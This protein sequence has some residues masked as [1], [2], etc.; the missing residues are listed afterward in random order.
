MTAES[1]WEATLE[2]REQEGF[3]LVKT[4]EEEGPWEAESSPHGSGRIFQ[5][6]FRQFRYQEASGPR[7]ALGRLRELCHLWL[8][9]DRRTKEQ[10]LDLLVLEQFLLVLPE[11][12]QA[13]VRLHRPESG[14]EAVAVV[15]EMQG[16]QNEP[17][18]WFSEEKFVVPACGSRSE[19]LEEDT[20]APGASQESL[21]TSPQPGSSPAQTEAG[22]LQPEMSLHLPKHDNP[23]ETEGRESLSAKEGTFE[24]VG[25]QR[26]FR[27][28][29]QPNILTA[30]AG[31]NTGEPEG[32]LE[33]QRGRPARGRPRRAA[34]GGGDFKKVREAQ[35]RPAAEK[36]S[37]ECNECGKAFKW[38]SN[39]RAH[40]RIHTGENLR[41]CDD[42]GKAFSARSTLIIHQRIH[43]GEKPYQCS[44]CGKAFS[45]HSSLIYHERVHTGEKP[46]KCNECGKIFKISSN[47]R[48]H[49]RI[50]TGEKPYECN[51]CGKA[52]RNR[53]TLKTH[54]RIHSGD[55]CPAQRPAPAGAQGGFGGPPLFPV[56]PFEDRGQVP[57]VTGP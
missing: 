42:C 35:K 33:S 34:P 26:P 47:L 10:I 36:R 29:R 2:P 56:E 54:L 51:E 17:G 4:E 19:A 30:S 37:Y 1:R 11:E 12:I 5:Q 44:E 24:K 18:Q 43:T 28:R 41:R 21:A 55:S 22:S 38:S 8:R 20:E 45:Q 31:G 39:L 9:P 46:Y 53:S 23:A 14:E 50:H 52:F 48:A 40:E 16:E 15:E 49:E 6:R 32:R 3:P 57:A 25:F 7:E 13:W 27:G